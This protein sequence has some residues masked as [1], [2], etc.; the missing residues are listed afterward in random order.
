LNEPED[1]SWKP[2][3][4]LSVAAWYLG[5][6]DESLEHALLA[7]EHNPYDQRLIDNYLVVQ[8]RSAAAPAAGPPLVDVV[9]LAY[10]KTQREYDMTRRC[11]ASLRASSPEVPVRIVVVETN[12]NLRTEEFTRDDA[13]LF[14][15]DVKVVCPGTRFGYNEFVQAGH[16]ACGESDARYFMVLNNDVVLFGT[17]FL[18]RMLGGLARVP[19]VSPLGLREAQWGLVERSVPLDINYDVNRAVCGWCLMFDKSILATVPF[20]VL[21]P[22]QWAWY[23]QDQA[24]AA[25][26]Q[27]HGLAHGL[28]T[29]ARALHLQA[30]SHH[31]LSEA[32]SESDAGTRAA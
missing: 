24:Y 19:S 5:F 27:A 3:D 9:I 4:L 17:G 26:L 25:A 16:R 6:H 10:S 30:S 21:F 20:D 22:R 13:A 2:H 12:V 29:A 8:A 32:Y 28:V 14:G 15:A 11:I 7:V 31:L 18:R 1:W 23:G